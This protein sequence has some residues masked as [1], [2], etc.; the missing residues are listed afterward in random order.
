MIIGPGRLDA[1]KVA[2]GQVGEQVIAVP[3]KTR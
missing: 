1:G 2:A 3:L